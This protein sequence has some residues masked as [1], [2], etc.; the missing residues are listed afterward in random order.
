MRTYLDHASTTPL[1]PEADAAL[2]RWLDDPA[3]GDPAR[4]HSEGR[5][6]RVAIEE[7][8]ETVASFFGVRPRQVIFVSGGT[9]AIATATWSALRG[10][11]GGTI[12]CAA[13]EHS[14]VTESARSYGSRGPGAGAVEWVPVSPGGVVDAGWVGARLGGAGPRVAL[15]HCQVANHE[16][17]TLQPAREVAKACRSAGVLFHAD[18][19]ASAAHLPLDVEEWGGDMVSVSSHKLGGPP[20]AGALLLRRGLRIEPLLRGGAQE[21]SRRAGLENLPGILGFAAA[22]SALATP[23]HLER[24]AERQSRHLSAIVAAATAVPGVALVGPADP[25]DR[26]PH[27]ACFSIEDIPG[28]PILLGLEAAGVAVHSGSACS[29]ESLEPSPVLGAMGVDSERTIRVSV[30]WSTVDDDVS[31]FA[32][33]FPVVVEKLRSLRG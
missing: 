18:A 27:I 9:E 30:G 4:I 16:V 5:I 8:R 31:A 20:G 32:R 22:V 7:S 10:T 21:R 25:A 26:L 28:E 23:G 17:G 29:S 19:C 3:A 24:E 33:T 13:I 14:A 1:R 11:P 12:L 15:V 2:R 6:A